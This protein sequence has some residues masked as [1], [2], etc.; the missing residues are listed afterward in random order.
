MPPSTATQVETLRLT[1]CTVYS[2]TVELATSARPG[3][4]SSRLPA[5]ELVVRGGHD[6]VDVL[7]DRRRLLG[8]RVGH[9]EAAAEV[10]DGKVAERRDR[11]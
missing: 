10:V 6:R 8:G 4:S 3:S 5:S 11:R 1:V 7:G 2:V 9:A